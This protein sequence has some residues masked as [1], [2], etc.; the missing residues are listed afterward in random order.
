MEIGLCNVS[1]VAFN[2][3]VCGWNIIDGVEVLLL[4][5]PLDVFPFEDKPIMPGHSGPIYQLEEE[6]GQS[7]RGTNLRLSR[8]TVREEDNRGFK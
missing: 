7:M 5:E 3:R 1:K 4:S 8:G 6:I 2:P